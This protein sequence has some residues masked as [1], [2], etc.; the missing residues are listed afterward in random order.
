M[1]KAVKIILF[2]ILTLGIAYLTY[3]VLSWKDTSG[4]YYSSVKMLDNTPGNTV[5]VAFVGTSHVYNGLYPGYLWEQ[6]GIPAFDMSIS[7]MDK[8]STLYYVKEFCKK[9]SPKVV[10][11]DAYAF[12]YERNA[13]QGN[14]YR[15]MLSMHLG[16]NNVNMIRDYVGKE[17]MW[18]YV[19]RW[20]IIHTRYKELKQDDFFFGGVNKYLRGERMLFDREGLDEIAD[21]HASDILEPISDK[22]RE[23]VDALIDVSLQEDFKLLFMVVPYGASAEDTAKLRGIEKYLGERGYLLYNGI[24]AKD[25]MNIVPMDDYCDFAHLNYYGALKFTEWISKYVVECAEFEDH[26][27]DARY[28]LWDLDLAYYQ[29]SRVRTAICSFLN[30]GDFENVLNMAKAD[31]GLSLVVVLDGEAP[32]SVDYNKLLEGLPVSEQASKTEGIWN[33]CGPV[34]SLVS[35]TNTDKPVYFDLDRYNVVK[36][37]KTE[38]GSSVYVGSN[39]YGKIHNGLYIM[40]WSNTDREVVNYWIYE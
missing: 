30:K 13:V 21:Y 5:D 22:N 4:E 40:L 36:I 23:I 34:V 17:D 11:V 31:P 9:Q 33:L 2:V 35:K 19:L 14:V 10:C 3:G 27:G 16:V 15:N 28:S 20:P 26:R 37:E 6:Y 12:L 18:D 25:E 39:E 7:G 29:E 8:Y 38:D 24:A 1:K 32:K